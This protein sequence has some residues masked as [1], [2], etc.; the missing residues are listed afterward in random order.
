MFPLTEGNNCTVSG[1]FIPK[2]P[3]SN[4]EFKED[5]FEIGSLSLP[6]HKHHA[7]RVKETAIDADDNEPE[8][9]VSAQRIVE[10][11][12]AKIQKIR[13]VKDQT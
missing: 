9:R 1:W 6:A 13:N 3:H 4:E 7:K 5:P 8:T 10:C 12:K 11:L 2:P